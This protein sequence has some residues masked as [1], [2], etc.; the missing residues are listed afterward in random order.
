MSVI[1]SICPF[2]GLNK[3]TDGSSSLGIPDSEEAP[4]SWS[5]RPLLTQCTLV[6]LS[7]AQTCRRLSLMFLLIKVSPYVPG[8]LRDLP[9]R[10]QEAGDS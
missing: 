4:K 9:K 7:N 2:S 3:Y 1:E 8:T 10:S 5:V 6:L